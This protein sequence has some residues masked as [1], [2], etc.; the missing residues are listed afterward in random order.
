[1][2]AVGEVADRIGDI[3]IAVLFAGAAIVPAKERLHYCSRFTSAR[4]AAAAEVL[5]AKVVIP[6]ESTAGHISPRDLP[7]SPRRSTRRV[8]SGL[9]R[10]ATH[11]EWIELKGTRRGNPAPH[12]RPSIRSSGCTQSGELAP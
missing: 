11:G 4:A 6:A 8:S 9:L 7:N 10:T 3:D 12:S 5:G 1:M 2:S